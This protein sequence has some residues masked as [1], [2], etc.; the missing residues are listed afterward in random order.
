MQK[1]QII[2]AAALISIGIAFGTGLFTMH[3]AKGLSYLSN[4]AAACANCHI[5]Q[6]HFHAWG[7]SSHKAI[8]KCNDCHTPHNIIGKYLSK[9][10][11]GFWHSVAFTTGLHPDPI[12]IKKRNL[13]ITEAACR[14]CH[15]LVEHYGDYKGED[16]R[17]THCH[18]SVGHKVR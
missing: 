17:C 7:Q 13:N 15:K 5:M 18:Q 6:E 10:D 2:W 4:D 14:S 16:F 3:F 12:T 8:A 1:A 9:A 11:N